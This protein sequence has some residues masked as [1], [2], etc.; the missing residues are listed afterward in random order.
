MI[1]GNDYKDN[2][3]SSIAQTGIMLY[4]YISLVHFFH[5]THIYFTKDTL[6]LTI[7]N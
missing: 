4:I 7:A 1:L 6:H 3:E 5:K 2:I